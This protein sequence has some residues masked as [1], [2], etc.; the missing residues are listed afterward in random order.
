MYMILT[1]VVFA[2][3]RVL[4][5]TSTLMQG[6][7]V[8]AATLSVVHTGSHFTLTFNYSAQRSTNLGLSTDV[9]NVFFITK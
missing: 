2:G 7:A 8:R 6:S 9:G 1:N 5:V 3:K 4:V